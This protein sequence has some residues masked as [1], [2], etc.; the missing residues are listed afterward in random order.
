MTPRS[1]DI[2]GP[3]RLLDR[4]RQTIRARH[5][6]FRTEKAYIGW[7]R[8][9]I[10]FYDKQHPANRGT[11]EVVR[12]LEHL[13]TV[14]HVAASTQNQAFSALLFLY[15]EVLE[16]KLTGLE[17]VIRAKR[18]QRLPVVLS[19]NEVASVLSRLEGIP[20]LMA[21]LMYGGGLRLLEC[22]QLRVKDLDLIRGELTVRDGK[23]RKGRVTVLPMSLIAPCAPT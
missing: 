7:I 10:F 11:P 16:T 18:P 22:A 15:G 5:Y 12:F 1:N 17:H 19:R 3:P 4:V 2:A 23:G 6:S 9:F 8:R 14:Q 21:S 13:A 20:Q